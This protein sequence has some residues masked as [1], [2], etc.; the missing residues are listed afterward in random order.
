MI[1]KDLGRLPWPKR[2]K[3]PA[4]MT[5][6]VSRDLIR[7]EDLVKI[8]DTGAIK[9]LGLKR[10]GLTIERGDFVAIMGQSGS[11]KSTLMNILGCLDR[12]TMG[13]YYLD[14]I[15]TAALSSDQLSEVRNRKKC[16]AAHDLC[17][18][19]FQ[20]GTAGAGHG[21]LRAGGLRRPGPAYA[22]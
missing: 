8:Y 16:G 1:H 10:I 17:P 3:L 14:G 21:T 18:Q 4:Y 19:P 7:L 2:R 13:H 12:P 22:Q 15:D 5:E 6:N 11:G 9:V 20:A